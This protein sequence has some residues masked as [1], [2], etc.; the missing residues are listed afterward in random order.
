MGRRMSVVEYRTH[1]DYLHLGHMES[2]GQGQSEGFVAHS[3]SIL[4]DCRLNS[5]EAGEK[6]FSNDQICCSITRRLTYICLAQDVNPTD[7][8][9]TQK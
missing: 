6:Q 4:I 9:G 7:V 3:L 5:G 1:V 2:S 8:Q